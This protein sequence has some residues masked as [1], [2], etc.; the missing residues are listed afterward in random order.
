MRLP[1]RLNPMI[2]IRTMPKGALKNPCSE[3][4][5]AFIMK[6]N[7]ITQERLNDPQFGV[8]QLAETLMLSRAH[9]TRKLICLVKCSPG[10]YIL[11]RRLNLA[12]RLLIEGNE[13]AKNVSSMVG[14]QNYSSFWRAFTREF[15][16]SPTDYIPE[17]K[18]R[19]GYSMVWTMPPTLALFK[20]LALVLSENPRIADLFHVVLKD[21]GDD[22]LT[23]DHL[24]DT[25]CISSSQL[26]RDLKSSL[27][28]TPMRLLLH[29]RLLYAA[30][31]LGSRS[32]SIGEVAHEAGFFDQA[33]LSRAFK[34]V[35]GRSP[36]VYKR[37]HDEEGFLK[38][39]KNHLMQQ[40]AML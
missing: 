17:E 38:W 34:V 32:L 37:E 28:V 19:V 21:I 29:L 16:C 5:K 3:S 31:L 4:D 2:P 20:S 36:S 11:S 13:P 8:S 1:Q 30:E 9:L 27:H 39:L 40:D 7:N 12:A 25:L 35:F 14:F 23:L 26:L 22:V 18:R 24:A 15:K 6:L 10:K 33:H